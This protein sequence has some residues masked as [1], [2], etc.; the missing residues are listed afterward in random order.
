MKKF[1]PVFILLAIFIPDA[2][3][4]SGCAAKGYTVVYINGIL[5]SKQDADN[6]RTN[7]GKKFSDLTKRTDTNFITGYNQSHLAGAGDV[8]ESISQAFNSSVSD[9]DLN[10][11]LQQVHPDVTTR[12]ILL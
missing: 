9:Y 10:T 7:L 8:L 2:A 3:S 1:V 4:A 6:D 11:I 12:K 5:T